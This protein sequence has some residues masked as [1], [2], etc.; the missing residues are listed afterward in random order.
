MDLQFV[1]LFKE[2]ILTVITKLVLG[3]S[4]GIDRSGCNC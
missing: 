2:I 1:D 3:G 4:T